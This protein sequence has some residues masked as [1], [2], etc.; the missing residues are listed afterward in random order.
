MARVNSTPALA[1]MLERRR[2]TLE[3]ILRAVA[4]YEQIPI[5]FVDVSLAETLRLADAHGI[6]AYDA[7]L[8]ACAVRQRCALLTLDQGLA[9]AATAAGV[10]VM[11]VSS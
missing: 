7:Y 9:R 10:D 5:R 6:Y 8:I 4:A 1:A 2:A 11:E 3:Q